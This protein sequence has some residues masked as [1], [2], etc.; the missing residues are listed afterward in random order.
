MTLINQ[1]QSESSEPISQTRRQ[2]TIPLRSLGVRQ[3]R[4]KEQGHRPVTRS[5]SIPRENPENLRRRIRDF[6]QS[7]VATSRGNGAATDQ[8][9][10]YSIEVTSTERS[11]DFSSCE[12]DNVALPLTAA[13]VAVRR[14]LDSRSANEASETR[15]SYC[16]IV[17]LHPSIYSYY[18]SVCLPICFFACLS[19]VRLF[20]L[21]VC[22]FYCLPLFLIFPCLSVSLPA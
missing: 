18:L 1:T 21:S 7:S 11:R 16:I 4:K 6:G 8:T 17:M 15:V 2:P 12:D 22:M 3:Q 5:R 9:N 20:R 13:N 19:A 10:R 14:R